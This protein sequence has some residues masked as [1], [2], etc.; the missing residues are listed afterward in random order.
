MEDQNNLSIGQKA[1]IDG[2]LMPF[3][4]TDVYVPGSCTIM[5]TQSIIL[6]LNAMCDFDSV[7]LSDYLASLGF[8]V[9]ASIGDSTVGW[10]LKEKSTI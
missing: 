8:K 3:E 10:I 7:S 4:P 6:E 5:D 2:Y 1:I 9:Y